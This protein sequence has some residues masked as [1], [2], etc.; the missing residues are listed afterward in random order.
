MTVLTVAKDITTVLKTIAICNLASSQT[1]A[2][3]TIGITIIICVL[4][5]MTVVTIA[6]LSHLTP[7]WESNITRII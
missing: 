1:M 4:G 6:K 5:L 2:L 7:L 3:A